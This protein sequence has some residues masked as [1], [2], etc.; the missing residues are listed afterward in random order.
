MKS[1][2]QKMERA[3][4]AK[5]KQSDD[6]SKRLYKVDF[7]LIIIVLYVPG[8]LIMSVSSISGSLYKWE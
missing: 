8:L 5:S 3:Y 6:Y 4:T 1:E 7:L 2:K